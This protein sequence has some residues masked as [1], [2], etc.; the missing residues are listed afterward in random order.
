MRPAAQLSRSS[1]RELK[2]FLAPSANYINTAPKAGQRKKETGSGER[3]KV[4]EREKE[5]KREK[6]EQ[7]QCIQM[8]A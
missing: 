3:E 7:G 6:E 4:R 8:S 2:I 1:N 5:N